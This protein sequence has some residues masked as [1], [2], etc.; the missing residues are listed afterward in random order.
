[1]FR[2]AA[3]SKIKNQSPATK[4]NFY[5][6]V[7]VTFIVCTEGFAESVT[8]IA[9][10]RVPTALGVNVT[11]NVQCPFAASEELQGVAPPGKA[12]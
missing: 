10:A 9:A 6:P 1:M 3:D 12:A 2:S 7:P 11:V 4:R 5:C 8:V